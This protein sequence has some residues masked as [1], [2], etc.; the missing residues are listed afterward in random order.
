MRFGRGNRWRHEPGNRKLGLQPGREEQ[1]SGG[2]DKGGA[3]RT[4][5]D[6]DRS[7]HRDPRSDGTASAS[8]ERSGAHQI[9]VSSNATKS[10][11][12][13]GR[14]YKGYIT[15]DLR[16]GLEIEEPLR[17]AVKVH[18]GDNS[19]QGH[20]EW[21]SEVIFPG[22]LSHPNL[23]KLIGYCCEDDH[24]VLVYEFMPLGSVESHLFSKWNAD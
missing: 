10:G 18:D 19:L 22:Q 14:V 5:L 6:A 12:G 21:L 8:A 15:K 11:G 17:V 2:K 9:R 20:R 7:A 24:R 3:A 1:E 4:Y 13:F 16:E 23:V